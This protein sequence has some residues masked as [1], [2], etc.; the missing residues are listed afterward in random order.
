MQF[1]NEVIKIIDNLCEK[2]GMAIDWMSQNVVPYL[3]EVSQ[4]NSKL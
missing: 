1:S 2:F 3:Q 4:K